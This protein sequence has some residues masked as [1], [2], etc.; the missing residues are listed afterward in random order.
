MAAK[1]C[2]LNEQKHGVIRIL[3]RHESLDL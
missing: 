3:G 1:E 2:G